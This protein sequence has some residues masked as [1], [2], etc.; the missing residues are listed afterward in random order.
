VLSGI[1]KRHTTATARVGGA[2]IFAGLIGAWA[3]SPEAS[4]SLLAPVLVAALPAFVFGLAEDLTKRVPV[5]PR[6]LATMASG[7]LAY[8]L[9]GARVLDTTG[10][11]WIDGAL[12]WLPFSVLFTVFAAAGVANA[13]NIIDGFNGLASGTTVISLIA[14]GLIAQACGDLEVAGLCF[15]ACAATAGFFLVNFPFGKLFLGD[16]GAYLLG[17]FLAWMAVMLSYR[18]PMISPWAPLLA[19]AY[20]VIE[21]LFTIARR[22]WARKHPG[23][24]DSDHLHSLVDVAIASRFRHTLSPALRNAIVS[25]FCWLIAALPALLSVRFAMR[26]GALVIGAVMSCAVYLGFYWYVATTAK[27][28]RRFAPKMTALTDTVRDRGSVPAR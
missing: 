23:K 5:K 12:A 28:R 24:P 8:V 27:T 15:V 25:P 17:F 1:Q 9:T 26:P 4:Q 14:L 13:V 16:G 3:L 10:V 20:P 2:A 22:L 6:L 19:C 21:T 11:A 7:A 18:N